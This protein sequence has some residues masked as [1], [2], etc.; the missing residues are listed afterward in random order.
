MKKK[1]KKKGRR[2]PNL[3]AASG[4]AVPPPPP[5]ER[6]KIKIN[7]NVRTIQTPFTEVPKRIDTLRDKKNA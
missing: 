2:E 7:K 1:K 3:H 5:S 4:Q 6:R